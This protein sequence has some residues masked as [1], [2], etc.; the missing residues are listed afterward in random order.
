MYL[1]NP[2]LN[3]L[4]DIIRSEKRL[5]KFIKSARLDSKRNSKGKA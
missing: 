5:A 4:L 2:K 3:L 1:P